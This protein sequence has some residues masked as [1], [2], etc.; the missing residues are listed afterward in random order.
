M[1]CWFC[2]DILLV[3]LLCWVG[4]CSFGTALVNLLVGVPT[5]GLPARGHV[6]GLVAEFAGVEKVPWSCPVARAQLPGLVG[7]ARVLG[8]RRILGCVNMSSAT[9]ENPSTPYR[10]WRGWEFSVSSKGLEEIEG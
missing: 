1:S 3:L 6:Q 5:W 8:G 4:S 2:L 10:I 7:G 9:T